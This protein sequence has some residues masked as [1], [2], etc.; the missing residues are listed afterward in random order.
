MTGRERRSY[1]PHSPQQAEYNAGVFPQF[2][3][4]LE[5]VVG[6][7]NMMRCKKVG[8]ELVDEDAEDEDSDGDVE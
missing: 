7:E 2:M 1:G 5:R 4:A 6:A 8:D 3:D